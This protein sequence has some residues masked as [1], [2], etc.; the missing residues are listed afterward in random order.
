M[1]HVLRY[2]GPIAVGFNGDD[3]GFM[4]YKDGIF[5]S[6]KCSKRPN[7]ALLVVGFGEVESNKGTEKYW[8][9]RNSWVCFLCNHMN[10]HIVLAKN[11]KE[12]QTNITLTLF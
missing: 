8:I 9:A 3:K 10:R 6:L 5:N 7:H 2:I 12:L 11:S 1:E 4:H